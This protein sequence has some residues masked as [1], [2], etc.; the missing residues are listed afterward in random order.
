MTSS[1]Q[2]GQVSLFLTSKS[3]KPRQNITK[4]VIFVFDQFY[5]VTYHDCN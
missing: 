5:K 3:L 2:E 1:A 4:F